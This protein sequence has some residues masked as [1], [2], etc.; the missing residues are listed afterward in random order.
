VSSNLKARL[1]SDLNAARRG[2][3]KSRTVLL[4]TTLSELKNREIET[5]EELTDDEVV[6]VV[7]RA[8]KQRREA[9]EQMRAGGREDLAAKEDQ[10]AEI[11]RTY[12]PEPL[13]EDQVRAWVREV[14][15]SGA[16]QM[17]PVMGRLMPRIKGRF[18]GK[19]ANRIVREELEA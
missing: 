2:R 11:L 18:D 13:S 17:G 10:E 9:A 14:I 4:T 19:E 15:A 7:N 16:D 8:V 5:R 3:E 12:L 1:Q 6:E